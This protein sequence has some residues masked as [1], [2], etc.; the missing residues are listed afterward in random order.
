MTTKRE[1]ADE[2]LALA[3]NAL[4]TAGHAEAEVVLRSS[5][6]GF[7]RFA[8]NE[9]GQ[10]MELR[11]PQVLVRVAGGPRRLSIVEASENRLEE[12]AIVRAIRRFIAS[13]FPPIS[14]RTAAR[15]SS[16]PS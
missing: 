7:A 15:P 9:L 12:S 2:L 13:S 6:R 14:C 3:R 10:H 4:H 11:E 8:M 16:S 5:R 1:S